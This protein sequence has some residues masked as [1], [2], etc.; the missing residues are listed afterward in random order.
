[1]P[2][3]PAMILFHQKL[4]IYKLLLMP[5]S[6]QIWVLCMLRIAF[7]KS[8]SCSIYPSLFIIF[9]HHKH[10][11]NNNYYRKQY[12]ILFVENGIV[13]LFLLTWPQVVFR[14]FRKHYVLIPLFVL[15]DQP[16]NGL[17]RCTIPDFCERT[18][19]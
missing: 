19:R 13:D 11:L 6:V 1:M 9:Q 3:L 10:S 16:F 12:S 7:I 15:Q 14:R 8:V 17:G 2:R 18:G 4:T 5:F